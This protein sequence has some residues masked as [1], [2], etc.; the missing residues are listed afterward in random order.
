MVGVRT[1]DGDVACPYKQARTRA[2]QSQLSVA[3]TAYFIAE[4]NHVGGFSGRDLVIADESDTL[5]GI[6]TGYIEFRV[7]QKW[8]NRLGLD[9][10]KKGSH[11]T[12]VTRWVSEVLTPA[13]REW[14]CPL[15]DPLEKAAEERAKG[16]G[17]RDERYI[18]ALEIERQGYVTRGKDDRVAAVD[19]EL[20]KYRDALGV[21]EPDKE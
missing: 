11:G 18:T 17:G 10:P 9:E 13:L 4:A 6:L 19:A 15:D 7:P 20:A 5:E 8:L 3:N 12:T 2:L 14:K 16:L 1:T 21:P